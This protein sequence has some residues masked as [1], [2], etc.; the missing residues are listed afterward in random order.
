MVALPLEPPAS[1]AT[2]V[3][4]P[5]TRPQADLMEAT[6]SEQRVVWLCAVCSCIILQWSRSSLRTKSSLSLHL[7]HLIQG[8]S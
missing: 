3:N 2:Q 8:F 6:L 7:Q 4:V 5:Q 1:I